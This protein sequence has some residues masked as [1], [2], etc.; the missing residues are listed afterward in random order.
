MR[1][2]EVIS[3]VRTELGV[4]IFGDSLPLLQEKAAE[5]SASSRAVPGAEDVSVG[6]ERRCDAARDRLDR[7]AI[8]RYGLNVADVREA[9]ETGIGGMA[10]TEVMD[11]RRRYPDRRSARR[12]V[13]LDARGGRPDADSRRR[14]AATVTLSQV[15]RP[16]DRRR[17]GGHRPRERPAL[18]GRAEQRA[19]PRPRGLRGRRA[20][21]G[22]RAGDDA[23]RAISSTYGGQFENQARAT[24]RLAL[25][26]PLVLLLIV[27]S[28]VCELRQAC[29]RRCSSC[30]TCRSRSLAESP[31]SGCA[32]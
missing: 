29:G 7:A 13:P 12:A 17:T 26:V 16:A 10:A 22:R 27:V 28:A 4:K 32:G 20:A 14:R 6:V 8:A 1:L 15:A 2:D 25:I 11:G 3:G 24:Q 30:S 9:V 18:R 21:R 5:V 23:R 31:R 19:R